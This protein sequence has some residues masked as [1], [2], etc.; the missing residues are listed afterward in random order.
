MAITSMVFFGEKDKKAYYP[1]YS[2][3]PQEQSGRRKDRRSDR[4]KINNYKRREV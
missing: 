1:S 4:L 3:E 2:D